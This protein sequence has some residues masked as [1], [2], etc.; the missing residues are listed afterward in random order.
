MVLVVAFDFAST[1]V[2][3]D[4][5]RSIEVI[6]SMHIGRPG[7]SVTRA[8]IGQVE[9]WI[10]V[11]GNPDRYPASFPGLAGPGVVARLARPWNR[12]GLPHLFPCLGVKGC[13]EATNP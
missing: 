9:L 1:R 7:G 5:G 10:V 13:D 11:P 8:P 12:I 6:P 4:H 3:S 2:Q